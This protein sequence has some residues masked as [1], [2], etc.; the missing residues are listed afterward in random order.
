MDHTIALIKKS[1]EGDKA[2]REQLVEENCGLVWCVVKRFYGRGTEKEDLFQIGNIGLIKAIDKFDLSFDVKF[3]TYAVPMI[4]GEI[5]RYLRD[6]GMIKVSRTLKELAYKAFLARERLWQEHG[7]EPALEDV[8][9]ELQVEKEDLVQAME[10][11]GEVE[12]IYRP[13]CQQDGSETQLLDKLVERDQ[14]EERMI[15]NMVLGQMLE[16]LGKEE[17]QLI[18]LRYFEEWTQTQVGEQ[19]G[20]SQVQVSR[21]EKKILERL[22]KLA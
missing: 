12:S 2:A 10:A 18:Y 5:K 21:L 13:V 7:H 15:D 6:D 1:H 20:M 11:S 3:S 22:R 9:R 16:E 19:M 8:A 4:S 17:R 14:K